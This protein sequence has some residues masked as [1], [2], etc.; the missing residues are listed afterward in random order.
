MP[1]PLV[2]RIRKAWMGQEGSTLPR[3]R[4]PG[5][6]VLRLGT[7]DSKRSTRPLSIVAKVSAL[8]SLGVP[9]LK[10]NPRNRLKAELQTRLQI[11][12]QLLIE[13]LQLN[14]VPL[15]RAGREPQLR[16][17]S[18]PWRLGMDRKDVGVKISRQFRL[19][20]LDDRYL[21][22]VYVKIPDPLLHGGN[23]KLAL[24]AVEESIPVNLQYRQA[25][26]GCEVLPF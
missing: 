26:Y 4:E 23:R 11:L 16:C 21:G 7:A 22:P 15:D 9:P 19:I 25:V 24:F 8:Y 17:V 3:I 6:G 5:S 1:Q 2:F 20:N 12:S 14:K 13:A 18:K 10:G